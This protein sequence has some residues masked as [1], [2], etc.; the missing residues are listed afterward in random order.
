M[1]HT[2]ALP[3][4]ALSS[5]VSVSVRYDNEVIIP[6]K[7]VLAGIAPAEGEDPSPMAGKVRHL[8]A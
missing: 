5:A 2:L 7:Q 1:D 8:F 6:A 3:S 4:K